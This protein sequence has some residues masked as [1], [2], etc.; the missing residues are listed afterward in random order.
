MRT[1]VQTGQISVPEV[2][3]VGGARV[4][5]AEAR[6][7]QTC[8]GLSMWDPKVVAWWGWAGAAGGLSR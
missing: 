3:E 8:G 7:A 1:S 4:K 5:C 2:P 6:A